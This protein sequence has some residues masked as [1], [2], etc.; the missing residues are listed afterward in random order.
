M[1]MFFI[2]E[3][4]PAPKWCSFLEN[5]TEELE[6]T[7]NYSVYEDFK[8]LSYKELEAIDAVN[9]I[10]TKFVK[11]YM[12]GYFMDWK[13]Y[14]KLK[15]LSEPFSY[16]KYLEDRKKEKMNKLTEE[17]IQ[18][19]RS[20]KYRVNQNLAS[21]LQMEDN[22]TNKKLLTDPRFEKLFK[23]KDYEIDLDNFACKIIK[24]IFILFEFYF[25][26]Y[27]N[28]KDGKTK[29]KGNMTLEEAQEKL[30]EIEVKEDNYNENDAGN[31]IVDPELIKL[32]EKLLSKKR[33][34]IDQLYGGNKNE[35]EKTLEKRVNNDSDE[36][37]DEYNIISKINKIES[38]KNRSKVIKPK[39]T[40]NFKDDKRRI[41]ANVDK[42]T[43]TK[44]K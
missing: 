37:G 39:I 29:K 42:L 16:D 24:N 13:L 31:K 34:K 10:G 30:N 17:R 20:N 4:G 32:K 7:K 6:E 2:P 11:Q 27:Y 19:N 22:E 38:R 5:I 26:F 9:L 3:I 1:E 23:G 18:F 28:K 35:M 25:K 14:K 12:H 41:L 36:E 21:E 8:F 43:K 15:A 40:Q 33:K 44:F